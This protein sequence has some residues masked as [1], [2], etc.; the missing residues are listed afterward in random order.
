L[1]KLNSDVAKA[2]K[3]LEFKQEKIVNIKGVVAQ[4]DSNIALLQKSV[5]EDNNRLSHY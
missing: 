5:D 3:E 1:L 2:A 4:I